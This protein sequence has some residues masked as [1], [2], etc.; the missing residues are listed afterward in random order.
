LFFAVIGT[1]FFLVKSGL[2]PKNLKNA[3]SAVMVVSCV[4]SLLV[5]CYLNDYRRRTHGLWAKFCDNFIIFIKEAFSLRSRFNQY[6]STRYIFR[7]IYIVSLT[8]ILSIIIKINDDTVKGPLMVF[9][10]YLGAALVIRLCFMLYRHFKRKRGEDRRGSNI[11]KD[12]LLYCKREIRSRIGNYLEGYNRVYLRINFGHNLKDE[13]D[14]LRLIVRILSTEYRKYRRSFWR[15]PVWMIIAAVFLFMSAGLLSKVVS[16]ELEIYKAA[17]VWVNKQYDRSR[18]ISGKVTLNRI[19]SVKNSAKLLIASEKLITKVI[20]GAEKFLFGRVLPCADEEDRVNFSFL[21]SLT[22]LY[23]C[24]VL[25][26]SSN[27][28]TFFFTTHRII[29]RRLK[30][31]NS[32]ITYSTDKEKNI[33][34]PNNSIIGLLFGA[35]TKKSR[36]IADAREIEKELQDIFE[37]FK[38]IPVLM[39]RPNFVVV[40]D[41]LDKVE[42]VENVQE[43]KSPESKAAFF[44]IDAA[45]ERQTQ[46]LKILSNMKYFLSTAEAKF[47]FIAGREMYDIYLADVSDRNNYIGSIFS[48]VIEVPSFL[49]DHAENKSQADMTTLTEDFVCRRLIPYDF[50]VAEDAY[51]L[52]HY[53][54]YLEKKIYKKKNGE[55]EYKIQKT[56][57]LLQQFIIYLAHVSKGAPQKMVQLF[58]SFIEV[59]DSEKINNEKYKYLTVQ[60]YSSSRYFLTFDF[61]QQYT[62]G[63]IAYLIT[64]I[65]NRIVEGNISENNDKLLVSSL[66]F[67]DFVFKFHRHSFSWKHLDISPEML[68]FNRAPELRPITEDLLN[69][70]AQNHVVKSNFSLFDYKFDS[71]IASEIFAMTK[72]DEVSSALLSFSLDETLPLK[73][74]YRDLLANT[75]KEYKN[76]KEEASSTQFIDAISS[77][78][79]VLGDLHYYDDELEEAGTYYR[80]AVDVLRRLGEKSDYDKDKYLDTMNPEYLYLY[81][82]NMLKVGMI[83]EK[84]KQYDLAY[85]I[86]GEIC[87]RVIRERNIYIEELQV[88]VELR[89]DKD[90]SIIFIKAPEKKQKKDETNKDKADNDKNYH[91]IDTPGLTKEEED[92]KIDKNIATFQPL[93]FKYISPKTNNMFF[94]KMTYEGL[95]LLYLPFIAKL[96]ILEKSHM[97]GITRTHLEQLDREFYFLTFIVDHEEANILEAD[98]YSRVADVLFY[99]NAD[100]RNKRNKKWLNDE[101]KDKYDEE[102]DKTNPENQQCDEEAKGGN[103]SCTACYY[104]HKALYKL[105]N[106]NYKDNWDKKDKPFPVLLQE[107]VNRLKKHGHCDVKFYTVLSRILSDWGNV[108]F[109]CDV[110][111]NNDCYICDVSRYNENSLETDLEKYVKYVMSE[112]SDKD[113]ETFLASRND[114]SKPQIA[115]AMYALSYKAFRNANI[116]KRAAYQMFKMLRLLKY[117]KIYNM[118]YIKGLSEKAVRFLLHAADNLNLYEINE[119]RKDFD[120][121]TIDDLIPLQYILVDSEITKIRILAKELELKAD[122]KQER[123]KDNIKKYYDIRVTSPYDIVY[124]IPARVYQLKLKATVNYEAY[125]MTDYCEDMQMIFGDNFNYAGNDKNIIRT[126]LIAESIFCL[127]EIL[128]LLETIGNSYIF[129]YSFIASKHNRLYFWIREYE[130]YEKNN[131][132]NRAELRKVQDCFRKILGDGW[133]EQ[134]SSHYE[135]KQ[136]LLNYQKSLEMHG[137]GKAYYNML[138]SMYFVR[139]DFNDRSAHYNIAEERHIIANDKIKDN[140]DKIKK[141]CKDPKLYNLD[142]YFYK[143][144]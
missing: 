46:I 82:R 25:V 123:L 30:R 39:G 55:D 23:L 5:Q 144:Q 49:T 126:Y 10:I 124:S 111:K 89:R 115:F 69:F 102:T 127:K 33:N 35:S 99:K 134:L 121:K 6:R 119:R 93:Y 7:I 36:G 142:N 24:S 96:Q 18:E 22:F 140:I 79:I 138:D 27:W 15:R 53:R 141:D 19:I 31:L 80:N 57:A 81:I 52:K 40:F 86:Y 74:Y 107:C 92:L 88:G 20:N 37:N 54:K 118:E 105:L 137:E 59:F 47:I 16:S 72:T 1:Q 87:R 98:F 66:R 108:F 17:A 130:E 29:M 71:V 128:R 77:L 51:D 129:T 116:Y 91:N 101:D 73:K 63:L 65:F 133:R 14:I 68:E 2:A 12:F 109:S 58:E 106:E 70:M 45:R 117:Y 28:L 139:D 122:K 48:S 78:Q 114:F 83:Y 136:A 50:P 42:P 84:R 60:Y 95:K 21:L 44:S 76:N 26:L 67:V 11:I 56:I 4:L 32:D 41:E 113:M 104:Y 112:L 135:N 85:L 34:M 8:Q 3:V 75:Q 38:R 103:I 110:N 64:P 97:G 61:Y 132:D 90:G 94:R 13:K 43:N 62:L 131:K 143:K 9:I 120:K 100:L 125:K